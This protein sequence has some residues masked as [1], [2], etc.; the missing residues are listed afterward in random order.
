[1]DQQSCSFKFDDGECIN[2]SI[3]L[4]VPEILFDRLAAVLLV[5]P[6]NIGLVIRITDGRGVFESV[7]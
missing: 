3:P 1:M 4:T 5:V 6:L 7:M 2:L